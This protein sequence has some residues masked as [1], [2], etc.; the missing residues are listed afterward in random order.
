MRWRV[1]PAL[2]KSGTDTD[3]LFGR[4]GLRLAEW[5]ASGQAGIVKQG[6][7]RAVYRVVLPRL[8]FIVKWYPATG[9]KHRVGGLVRASEAR[10]ECDQALAVAAR[11]VPTVEPIAV[12][13]ARSGSSCLLLRT[14]PAVQPLGPFLEW[15]L[16]ECD[17]DR[18][19][20]L[21][22]ELARRLGEF[23]AQM[24]DAG[25]AHR[26]LHPGN[27]L[28]TLEDGQARFH[29]ADV[30]QVCLGQPLSWPASRANLVILNRWFMLR[31][32]RTD[33]LRFWHA[34]RAARRTPGWSDD[35]SAA[36]ASGNQVR[37]GVDPFTSLAVRELE[38]RALASNLRFWLAQDRRCLENNRYYRKVSSM[39]AVG[40]VVADLGPRAVAALLENPDAVFEQAKG[41]AP[42]P[43]N[44]PAPWTLPITVLKDSPSSTV[45]EL[46]LL[47]DGKPR[48]VVLKRFLVT[49]WTD[50][51]V[52]LVRRTPALRSYVLG[53]GLRLRGLPTPRP[54]GVWHRYRAGLPHEGYLLTEKV[55]GALH[56]G[57]FLARLS[58]FPPRER[59]P[60]LRRVIDRVARL[61]ADLHERRLSHRDLKAA[62]LL[63][64]G[65]PWSLAVAERQRREGTVPA[66]D[67]RGLTDVGA[68]AVAQP[69][70]IDLVGVARHARLTRARRLQNLARLN[71]SFLDHPGLTRTD[72]LRFLRAYLRWG[73]CGRFGWKRWWRQI[74]QATA[75]K[76]ER[77]RR[78]RRPLG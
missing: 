47:L 57:D 62:N 3:C 78:N 41:A 42:P 39:V 72:R 58:A 65:T 30:Q 43:D 24:H 35:C 63:M 73:L 15:H 60:I 4:D 77:N 61:V 32:S 36:N 6:P 52:A 16:D 38:R 13:E 76:V 21:R 71:V 26:D 56:L 64:S 33:R 2:R 17:P 69:W 59:A 74:A 5:L 37:R 14:L 10:R 54:L 7:H 29:L 44:E 34:Y 31:A 40:H 67:D 46:D 1:L 49:S 75:A 53:H 8:D 51:L 11:G 18:A 55:P 70:L 19:G 45:V 25:V 20:R 22:R 50:P 12:G 27:L 66:G 28:L 9:K 48:R 68:F 23:L